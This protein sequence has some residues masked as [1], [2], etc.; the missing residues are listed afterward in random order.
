LKR[1]TEGRWTPVPL[2]AIVAVLIGGGAYALA[3]GGSGDATITACV[4]KKGGALYVA[5]KCG[6]GDKKLSWN[7]VGPAGAPGAAGPTGAQGPTGPAGAA[8]SPGTT[9]SQGAGATTLRFDANATA[10][11]T[12]TVLG[13][14]LGVTISADCT[15]P[16]TGQAKLETFLKTSDGSWTA[17]FASVSD[18]NGTSN[19]ASSRAEIPAGTLV[20]PAVAANITADAA[21]N[22]SNEH[23][24]I[25]QTA[26]QSGHMLWHLTAKTTT[27]PASQQCHLAVESFPSG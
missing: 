25:L 3:D 7:Q 15:I 17:G 12:P 26:P 4:H 27:S 13:T 20:S 14:V 8:G 11:P 9:V 1:L 22:E 19:T 23:L 6:K 24:D 5:R 2:V 18:D 10:S 21:G 16:A